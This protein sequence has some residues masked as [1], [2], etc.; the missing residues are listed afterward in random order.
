MLTLVVFVWFAFGWVLVLVVGC[1]RAL[2][3]ACFVV[4]TV[5]DLYYVVCV[6][7]GCGICLLCVLL[8][9][10]DVVVGVYCLFMLFACVVC[11]CGMVLFGLLVVL[12]SGVLSCGGVW[13]VV[14]IWCVVVLV[15]W[16]CYLV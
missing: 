14:F 13:G 7:V 8:L 16:C 10:D 2:F 3:V 15:G 5:F 12:L 1:S 4:G 6:W 9:F 11:C